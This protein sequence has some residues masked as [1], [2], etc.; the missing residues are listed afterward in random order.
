[1]YGFKG[2]RIIYLDTDT[3][4]TR[5]LEGVFDLMG[6]APLGVSQRL[7]DD[8]LQGRFGHLMP[9]LAE[10][11][12]YRMEPPNI[13][14]GMVVCNNFDP[15]LI[16]GMWAEVMGHELFVELLGKHMTTEEYAIAIAC[17]RMFDD[18][19]KVW[20]IPHE[21]HGNIYK[22]NKN[23]GEAEVPWVMHYHRPGWAKWHGIEEWLNV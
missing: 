10:A 19:A 18:P 23:F 17:A 7:K 21:I 3:I 2:R 22:K 20:D 9:R 11:F 15:E 4:V 5:D 13:S 12:E 14:T 8:R 16:Y 6:D 1:M